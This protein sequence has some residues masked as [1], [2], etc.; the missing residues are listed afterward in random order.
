MSVLINTPEYNDIPSYKVVSMANYDMQ[1]H[2]GVRVSTNTTRRV[3]ETTDAECMSANDP[4][5]TVTSMH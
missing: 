5:V 2:I 1:R 3:H 4:T